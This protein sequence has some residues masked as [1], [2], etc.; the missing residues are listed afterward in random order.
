M[1]KNVISI[2][3]FLVFFIS[4]ANAQNSIIEEYPPNMDA[5][6][7]ERVAELATASAI[8]AINDTLHKDAEA[9]FKIAVKLISES[10]KIYNIQTLNKFAM[11]FLKENP[12]FNYLSI[13]IDPNKR[14]GTYERVGVITYY[15]IDN[16]LSA[17]ANFKYISL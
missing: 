16:K 5:L 11:D 2:F 7:F 9:R 6:I 4:S 14:Q 8:Y 12:N 10:A 3:V 13:K 17:N 15:I 1:I